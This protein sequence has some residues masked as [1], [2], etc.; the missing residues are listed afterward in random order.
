MLISRT[1]GKAPPTKRPRYDA[2]FR[3]ESLGLASESRSAQA[4]AHT[5]N[6]RPGLIYQAGNPIPA[7]PVEAAEVRA[8]R[9]A[10]KRLV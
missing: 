3:A 8:L 10:N 6:I 7:D 4:T 1:H 2:V 9:M 5:L